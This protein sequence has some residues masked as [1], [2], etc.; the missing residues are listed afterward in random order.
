MGIY[1]ILTGVFT[2][3]EGI[4]VSKWKNNVLANCPTVVTGGNFSECSGCLQR[5][6]SSRYRDS[7]V[8]PVTNFS[9]V[10][11]AMEDFK[12][13]SLKTAYRVKLFEP[14]CPPYFW[15]M[16]PQNVS[17]KPYSHNIP[18]AWNLPLFPSSSASSRWL[19]KI[20]KNVISPLYLKLLV[21]LGPNGC[22][23]AP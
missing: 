1:L 14:A 3:L 13:L 11:N 23:P 8:I 7:L 19:A 6:Q 17:Q 15:L 21:T 4:F 18:T 16:S 2:S 12:C 5:P 20:V 9:L 22:Q 10:P